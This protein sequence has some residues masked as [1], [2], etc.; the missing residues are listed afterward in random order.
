M[1]ILFLV[2]RMPYPPNKGDKIRSFAELKAMSAKH[3]V[4]LFCFYDDPA[5]AGYIADLRKY[6]RSCNA[7]FLS[8]MGSRVRALLALAQHKP[9]SLAYYY[10]ASMRAQVQQ[11]LAQRTYDLVF[12]FSSAM[13]Q[14]SEG[15]AVPVV[16]DFVDVDSDKWAQYASHSRGPSSW[17]WGYEA[18]ALGR[19]E[20]AV[21]RRSAA[22]VF[23]T[24]AEANTF[25]GR[26]PLG[27][28]HVLQNSLDVNF[29]DPQKVEITP[30]IRALQPYAVF[31]GQMD[32]YPNVD[33]A[34]YFYRDIFPAV[35]AQF[36][37]LKFVIAGRNPTR[38][39]RR[40]AASDASLLV[41]GT[42]PDMRPYLRGACAAVLPLRMARGVQ[43]KVLEAMAMGLPV[44]T[45]TVVAQA[46]PA[47]LSSLLTI[48]DRPEAM[49]EKL[50]GLLREGSTP[51]VPMLRDA[52][53]SHFGRQEFGAQLE[54]IVQAARRTGQATVHATE[55]GM[56]S[57]GG[58]PARDKRAISVS[59]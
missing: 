1:Q 11:A 20:E 32:Y 39:L 3:E 41:T 6:S 49:A 48:E 16:T 19:Y 36:P 15:A 23:C 22:N 46:L 13:A 38:R 50:V 35:K 21:A 59:G 45:S 33:A 40:M 29:F 52:T 55:G 2:H 28:V 27:S 5:D 9:F 54:D 47:N 51:P 10:T 31:P 12:V 14:Y 58:V 42:V 44:I 25:A 53:V 43:N 4:D 34:E 18:R 7:E 57:A 26:A 24:E 56:E 30:E 8:P 17:L 37:G